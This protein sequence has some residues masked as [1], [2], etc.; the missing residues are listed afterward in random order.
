VIGHCLHPGCLLHHQE[1]THHG[2]QADA[3]P[4]PDPLDSDAIRQILSG[5][6]EVAEQ[7]QQELA[8]KWTDSVSDTMRRALIG[9]GPGK[10]TGVDSFP[11][12]IGQYGG[13]DLDM[14]RLQALYDQL[15]PEVSV[16]VPSELE[17]HARA[18]LDAAGLPARV[19]VRSSPYMPED[20]AWVVNETEQRRGLIAA[21]KAEFTGPVGWGARE[22]AE[23]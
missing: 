8:V 3:V 12:T 6:P 18:Q 20:V 11:G 13:V 1:H 21:A 22:R 4:T 17:D 9:D 19:T 10:F 23:D 14:E 2:D 15:F 5:I 7:G 16:Y